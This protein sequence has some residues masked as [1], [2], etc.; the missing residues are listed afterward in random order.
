MAEELNALNQPV[1]ESVSEWTVPPFPEKS[2]MQGTWCRLEPLDP[3]RHAA[4]LYAANSLD[5]DGMNWT[6]LPYGPFRSEAEY[7]AW[8][9]AEC[10]GD[11]PLFFAIVDSETQEAVG[12][13]SYLRIKPECGSIE[14]GHLCFS[15]RLQRTR[16][17]TESMYLMMKRAFELGYRR[18]EWKCHAKN[19][20]SRQA[21]HRLGLSFEGVFRQAMVVKGRSRDTAWFAA[22]DSEWPD[23]KAAFASWLSPENFD[24]EGRQRVRLAEFTRPILKAVFPS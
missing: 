10:Q 1:G 9:R 17:A 4:S 5:A 18:Y 14:V 13:C 6:Y 16:A 19:A 21:A 12:V 20:P 23:L 2:P 3:D 11:D 8:I 7:T 24:S 22:I 15:P